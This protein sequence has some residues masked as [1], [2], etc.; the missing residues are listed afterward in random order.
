MVTRDGACENCAMTAKLRWRRT[1][2]RLFVARADGRPA[3]RWKERAR[4]PRVTGEL[5][6]TRLD[7]AKVSSR[8]GADMLGSSMRGTYH[9][10]ERRPAVERCEARWPC[11]GPISVCRIS[12]SAS[13]SPF[14]GRCDS[15][16][17]TEPLR[18]P[19][20]RY[21][22]IPARTPAHERSYHGST[23]EHLQEAWIRSR[24]R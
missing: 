15:T 1:V 4:R 8:S 21:S 3:M 13:T 16:H 9:E 11:R 24:C 18:T 10:L 23:R 2:W 17:S 22:T 14:L 12:F 20:S 6:A 5:C 7:S 19:Q